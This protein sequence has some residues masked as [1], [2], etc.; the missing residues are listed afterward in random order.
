MSPLLVSSTGD[1]GRQNK[2]LRVE[3]S[4]NG[5][6]QE[7]GILAQAVGAAARHR[8]REAH[9]SSQ[10]AGLPEA[11]GER[12]WEGTCFSGAAAHLSELWFCFL[13]PISQFPEAGDFVSVACLTQ[14]KRSF[15]KALLCLSPWLRMGWIAQRAGCTSNG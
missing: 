14:N 13:Q 4:L 11:T 15:P 7:G 12:A 5:C 6:E 1:P 9:A 2:K 3:G 10:S 8:A